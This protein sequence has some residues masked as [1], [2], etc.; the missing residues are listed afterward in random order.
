MNNISFA[1]NLPEMNNRQTI[2]RQIISGYS[3]I[4]MDRFIDI[5]EEGELLKDDII[6]I[7]NCGAYTISLA[8]LFIE[9]F[10]QVVVKI[11]KN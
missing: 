7:M 4:E 10:P 5:K 6:E 1:Y 2:N 8:P 11:T 3:C 9:Y